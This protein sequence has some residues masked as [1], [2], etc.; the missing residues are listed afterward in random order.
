MSCFIKR[1]SSD[2]TGNQELSVEGPEFPIILPVVKAAKKPRKNQTRSWGKSFANETQYESI[3]FY[4]LVI[5]GNNYFATIKVS[6]SSYKV[7]KCNCKL[8]KPTFFLNS[9]TCDNSISDFTIIKKC[10]V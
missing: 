10:I 3:R 4:D 2:F 6:S 8:L 1:I 7:F 5:L 9:K